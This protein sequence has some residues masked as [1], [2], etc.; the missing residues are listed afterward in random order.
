MKKFVNILAVLV[1]NVILA[2]GIA[3]F[4]EPTGIISGGTT[5]VGLFIQNYFGLPVSA[6]FGIINVVCFLLGLFI[7][8]WK[9]AATTLLSSIIFPFILRYFETVP[10][11]GGLTDDMLLSAILAGALCGIG[12]GIVV[13]FHSSTGGL[14]IP[15][16]IINKLFGFSVGTVMLIQN[17][18]TLALQISF[19]SSEQIL[20]GII[21]VALMSVILDKV[22]MFGSQQAQLMIISPKYEAI[23]EEL[24]KNHVGL[25]VFPIE[26]GFNGEKQ[27]AIL[28]AVTP[29]RLPR[30][31][32][33]VKN[34]DE[35]SFVLVNSTTEVM[36]RGFTLPR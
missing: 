8:G 18:L 28:C 19:S 17:I 26:T 25:T 36:G 27:K 1:G 12:V 7:L 20:Y 32:E 5:G 30:V 3:A 10:G 2:F 14:D 16:L 35:T 33:L 4:L 29:R 6:T 34:M 9:F 21:Q 13:R 22:L 11:I 24:I 23:K 31:K 15:P